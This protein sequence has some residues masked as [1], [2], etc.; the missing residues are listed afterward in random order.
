VTGSAFAPVDWKITVQNTGVTPAGVDPSAFSGDDPNIANITFKYVGASSVI[1]PALI[2]GTGG[3][4]AEST[5]CSVDNLG[6]YASNTHKY[7]PG[8]PDNNTRQANG[9]F[10]VTPRA[11]PEGSSLTLFATAIVPFAC[12]FAKRRRRSA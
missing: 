4:G 12:M 9:G 6:T 2:G 8:H 5:F 1:G 3:F 7:N 10:L 11:V